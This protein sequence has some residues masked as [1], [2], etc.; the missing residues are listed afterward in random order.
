M[1]TAGER[2]EEVTGNIWCGHPLTATSAA[3]FSPAALPS[4]GSR[5]TNVVNRAHHGCSKKDRWKLPSR[6]AVRCAR[7]RRFTPAPRPRAP[8]KVLRQAG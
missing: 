4:V 8:L 1:T 2:Y 3:Q 7:T 5:S 6:A